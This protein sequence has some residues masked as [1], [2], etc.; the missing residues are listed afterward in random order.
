MVAT[1]IEMYGIGACVTKRVARL[2]GQQKEQPIIVG[3]AHYPIQI[4]VE[5]NDVSYVYKYL[6]LGKGV[7]QII[8]KERP[9]GPW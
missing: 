1:R 4:A 7:V 2:V 9:S 3:C 6:N 8:G 5:L